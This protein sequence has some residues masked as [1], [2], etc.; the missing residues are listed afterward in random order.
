MEQDYQG[1]ES[2]YAYDIAILVL[3]TQVTISKIV[4]PAC[5]DWAQTYFIPNGLQGKVSYTFFDTQIFV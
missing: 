4:S 5:L 3:K 1:F 2:S